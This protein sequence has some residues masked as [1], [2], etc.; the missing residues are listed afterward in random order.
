MALAP[1]IG[2]RLG[3]DGFVVAVGFVA[4]GAVGALVG[5]ATGVGA[6][7]VPLKTIHPVVFPV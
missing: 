3:G 6:I 2:G 1:T 4:L 5:A 7:G